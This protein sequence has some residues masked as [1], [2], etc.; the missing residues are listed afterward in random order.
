MGP[1]PVLHQE[2]Q[3]PVLQPGKAHVSDFLHLWQ[4]EKVGTYLII[5][6]VDTAMSPIVFSRRKPRIVEHGLRSVPRT[7]GTKRR[8]AGRL[9][10]A[11]LKLGVTGEISK[12]PVQVPPIDSQ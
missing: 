10:L 3:F 11:R 8:T 1:R 2:A 12:S 9:F 5:H 4:S 6:N 7:I